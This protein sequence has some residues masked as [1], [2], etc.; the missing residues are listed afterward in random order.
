MSLQLVACRIML[1]HYETYVRLMAIT[2][3]GDAGNGTAGFGQ[4]AVILRISAVLLVLLAV[5]GRERC[6]EECR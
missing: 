2:I 5:G 1:G 6:R 4:R 3:A